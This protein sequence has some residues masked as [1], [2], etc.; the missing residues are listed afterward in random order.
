MGIALPQ[1]HICLTSSTD[2]EEICKPL[3]KLSINYFSFVRSFSDG[4]HIRLSNNAAWTKHYYDREF[5]KV[6]VKQAPEVEGSILW[7]SIDKYPLFHEASEFFDVD[8]GVVI[9]VTNDDIVERYYFGSTRENKQV[10]YVYLHKLDLLA[11]F[12]LHFKERANYLISA[13]ENSK[14]VTSPPLLSKQDEEFYSDTLVQSFLDDIKIK[15]VCIRTKGQDLYITPSD[16]KIL[17]LMKCGYTSKAIS[18]EIGLKQKTVEIYRDKLK[19]KLS[20]YT[21]GDLLTIAHSN[22]LLDFKLF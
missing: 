21:R 20:Q 16:A 15:S 7:S 13:A 18:N 11:R 4:S 12:I 19:E 8:N 5:Y 2:M 1:N 17:S 10:K 9:V 14:I 6:A 22:S 3:A